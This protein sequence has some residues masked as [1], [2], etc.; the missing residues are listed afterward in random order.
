MAKTAVVNPKRRRRRKRRRNPSSSN[1]PRRR[2]RNYGAAAVVNAPRR[3]R[4]RRRYGAARRRRNPA[5]PYAPTSYY[6]RPNPGGGIERMAMDLVRTI[7]AATGGV[8]AARFAVRQAGAFE[9]GKDGV[10]EPGAK[11]AVAILIAAELA[12][13]L[14]GEVNGAAG[15]AARIAALGFGGD[16]F[17]RTRFMRDS[18]L[19]RDHISLQGMGAEEQLYVDDSGQL[20]QLSGGGAALAGFQN[21]SALGDSYVDSAGNV[22]MATPQGWALAG[23][24]GEHFVQTEDGR[25]YQMSG[26]SDGAVL[27]GF[28]NESALGLPPAYA[29]GSS[30]FGYSPR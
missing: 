18:A 11:H 27:D 14:L 3:R 24:L 8:M 21:E 2:R 6:R 30:S 13:R 17:L 23:Q 28:Q 15:D 19:I 1:R 25:L 29:N 10:L 16:L 5:S 7:P 22:F 12:G 26:A 4:R 9:P 20:F